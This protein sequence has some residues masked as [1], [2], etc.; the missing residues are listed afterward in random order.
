MNGLSLLWVG[1]CV[2]CCSAG[3]VTS[4][5]FNWGFDILKVTNHTKSTFYPLN[6]S[7]CVCGFST[8]AENVFIGTKNWFGKL[9][10]PW[11]SDRCIQS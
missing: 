3:T 11:T 9:F 4:A 6:A 2:S 1:V 5:G 8:S 10:K 7:C